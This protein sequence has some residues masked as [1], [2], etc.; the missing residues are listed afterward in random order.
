[1]TADE[2]IKQKIDALLRKEFYENSTVDVSDGYKDNIHIVVVSNRFS[3]KSEKEKEDMLWSI[4]EASDLSELEKN[5]ISLLIPY[6]P[7]ELK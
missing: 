7:E 3:E 2:Q 4:I 5:K 6:S 1:M